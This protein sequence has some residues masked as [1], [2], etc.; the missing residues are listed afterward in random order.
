MNG[1]LEDMTD[2]IKSLYGEITLYKGGTGRQEGADVN[3]HK[4]CRCER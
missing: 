4:I 1:L 2:W 3:I